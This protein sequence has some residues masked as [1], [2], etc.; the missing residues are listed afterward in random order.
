[1]TKR[2]CDKCGGV[3]VEPSRG[4]PK[5]GLTTN[6]HSGTDSQKS[7]DLCTLCWHDLQ[8]FLSNA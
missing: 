6:T 3:C 1:M 8:T 5:L 4:N 7:Y 2:F